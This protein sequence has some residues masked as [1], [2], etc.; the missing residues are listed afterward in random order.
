M[1]RY[2]K[3]NKEE[4]SPTATL[5]FTRLVELHVQRIEEPGDAQRGRLH[6]DIKQSICPLQDDSTLIVNVTMDVIGEQEIN[7][8]FKEAFR[9]ECTYEGGFLFEY[10]PTQDLYESEAFV[11]G[12]S[13]YILPVVAETLDTMLSRLGY[14]GILLP[15][16]LKKKDSLSVRRRKSPAK[17]KSK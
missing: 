14:S 6:A 2:V 10:E 11:S 3:Q 17:P 4:N 15:R 1:G 7:G 9:A 12:L 8:E 5:K 13:A 16:S